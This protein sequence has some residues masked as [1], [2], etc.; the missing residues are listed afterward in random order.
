MRLLFMSIVI[1]L[2]LLGFLAMEEE[3]TELNAVR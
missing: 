3:E 2:S 1:Q